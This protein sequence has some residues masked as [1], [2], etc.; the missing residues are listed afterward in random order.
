MRP[1]W[2]L[3]A[4]GAS[5][6]ILTLFSPLISPKHLVLYVHEL[7]V[8]NMACGILLD[9]LCIFVVA[10]AVLYLVH[11]LAPLPRRVAS[12]VLAGVV[13][14][15]VVG[16]AVFLL[17]M[18][19]HRL[20]NQ[21][22]DMER[23]TAWDGIVA[24][25]HHFQPS[26][27]VAIPVLLGALAWLRPKYSRPVIQMVRLGLAS[28]AFCAVWVVPQLLYLT[29]GKQESVSF[30][31]STSSAQPAS[32][33]RIV[34]ILFDELS[35]DLAFDHPPAGQEFPNLQK[36][37]SE[38]ISLGNIRPAGI[39][40]ARIIPSILIGQRIDQIRSTMDGKLSYFDPSQRSWRAYDQRATL[41]EPARVNGWNP[42][43][44]G[45]YI[46]YCRLLADVLASCF[47][48]PEFMDLDIAGLPFELWS[49]PQGGSVLASALVIPRGALA[50]FFR[51]KKSATAVIA[52]Q[53][54][55]EYRTLMSQSQ[56]LIENGN[57]HFLFIHL[58]VPH[59]PGNYDR[60]THALRE[61]GNYLDNLTW[62]DDTL[63]ELM[64]E[65]D[66][67]PQAN[68]TTVIVSSDHSWRVP[69][70]ANRPDWTAEEERISRGRFEKRPVFLVHFPGQQTGSEVESLKSELL[71]HDVIV[72]MLEGK[73]TSAESLQAMVR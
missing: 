4:T 60:K 42:G 43:V 30:D 17:N 37:R 48:Q 22:P 32:S 3:E 54:M 40:T 10:T 28:L 23:I 45:F 29:I 16:S 61:G 21:L 51:P 1:R 7:P 59:P 73:I 26:L 19:Y 8:S 57:I 58:P 15:C 52:A 41:F 39:D 38:S 47:W 62:A 69:I 31:H 6:L 36:L 65:I 63:G 68:Q 35:Y 70:W 56:A 24:H 72:Q 9:M 13:I 49:A 12:G 20:P 50:K 18:R 34:W 25:W 11:R 5:L 53:R 64:R 44:V 2:F 33:R 14:M 71:E 55:L 27:A 46:P 67:G 66:R